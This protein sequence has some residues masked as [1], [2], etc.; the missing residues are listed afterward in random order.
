M[1]QTAVDI[2]RL[3]DEVYKLMLR[4]ARKEKSRGQSTTTKPG[5]R[6]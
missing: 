4:E 1:S 6:R 5:K 2:E 3:A